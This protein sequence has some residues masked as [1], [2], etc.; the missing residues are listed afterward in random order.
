MDKFVINGPSKIKGIV[1]CSGSKN[2]ALPLLAATLLFDKP[3]TL[4]N[5]PKKIPINTQKY[6]NIPI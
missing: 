1:T 3:V 4:K 2:L 6:L 5:L